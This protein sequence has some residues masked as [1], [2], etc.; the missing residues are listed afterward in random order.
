M[1]FAVI[2]ISG[3]VNASRD[4]EDTLKMLRLEAP[5]NCVLV[6][7][8]AS[9]KGMLGH[10]KDFITWGEVEKETL[11]NLLE[12]RLRLMGNKKIEKKSLK[13]VTGFD[14]FEKLADELMKGK[15]LKDFKKLK[16]V[17]RL[18]PPSKGFKSTREGFPR[19]DLSYRG[20]E[21][22]KLLERMM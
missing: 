17:L 20:K 2:R 5:N 19:G 6:P 3:T 15:K 1:M 14:S 18:T 7:E 13:E 12:K 22:N 10:V 11:V 9:F 16:P 21:I 4:V 8:D